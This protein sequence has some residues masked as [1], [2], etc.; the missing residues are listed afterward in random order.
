VRQLLAAAMSGGEADLDFSALV[1]LF[2]RL[3]GLHRDGDGQHP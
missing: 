3:A 1:L 2:E